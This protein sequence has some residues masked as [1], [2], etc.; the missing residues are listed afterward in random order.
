MTEFNGQQETAITALA[1]GA[2]VFEAAQ[3]AGVTRETVSRWRSQP[4]FDQEVRRRRDALWAAHEDRLL[5][6]VGECLDGLYALTH[7]P[8]Y[9][10][11]EHYDPRVR[12]DAIR[13]VLLIAGLIP[14]NNPQ[15]QINNLLAQQASIEGA[16]QPDGQATSSS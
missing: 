1:S 9:H 16:R 6:M 14:A 10:G 13:L 11:P 12:L 15:V 2:R 8:D 4:A 3:V 5:R 7:G